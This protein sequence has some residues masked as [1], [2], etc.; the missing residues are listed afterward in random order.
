MGIVVNRS[1]FIGKFGIAQKKPILNGTDV[2]GGLDNFINENEEELL[3]ELF[4][5][6]MYEEFKQTPTDPIYS[7]ILK[8][9]A[10]YNGRYSRGLK[11]MLVKFIY[12]KYNRLNYVNT[13]LG[14]QKSK[15]ETTERYNSSVSFI[16]LTT[17]NGAVNSF[18]VILEYLGNNRAV[19]TKFKPLI[20][21]KRM[22]IL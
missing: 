13:S 16:N 18:N 10:G 8:P 11:D 7:P 2:V 3:I 14:Q 15:G 6:E 20:N 22:M 4:G 19:F 21:R 5:I 1:D 17:Y 12:V 9:L